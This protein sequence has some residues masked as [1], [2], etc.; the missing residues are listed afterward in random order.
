MPV[1]RNS[2]VHGGGFGLFA[3]R[4]FRKGEELDVFGGHLVSDTLATAVRDWGIGSHC[5]RSRSGL[6]LMCNPDPH[7]AAGRG[8]GTAQFANSVDAFEVVVH[9]QDLERLRALLPRVTVEPCEDGLFRVTEPARELYNAAIDR[10]PEVPRLVAARDVRVGEEL[11]TKYSSH[12]VPGDLERETSVACQTLRDLVYRG[13]RDQEEDRTI[14]LACIF[15]RLTTASGGVLVLTLSSGTAEAADRVVK[16]VKGSS[17]PKV[18]YC[19]TTLSGD[20]YVIEVGPEGAVVARKERGSPREEVTGIELEPYFGPQGRTFFRAEAMRYLE[21]YEDYVN[22]VVPNAVQHPSRWFAQLRSGRSLTGNSVLLDDEEALVVTD[23]RWDRS[24]LERLHVVCFFKKEGLYTIRDLRGAHVPLLESVMKR[25]LQA[26]SR[27]YRVAEEDLKLFF[28]Y[29]PRVYQLHLHL[30]HLDFVTRKSSVEKAHSVYSVIENL[31]LD[32][33]YY[34]KVRL[35]CKNTMPSE[36]LT[37]T[38][39]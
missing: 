27:R 38:F 14:R 13:V 39:H 21:P 19:A 4:D 25:A 32:P 16:A 6:V 33:D 15:L 3:D 17:R 29:R 37:R 22:V 2:L 36:H 23:S 5:I 10:S 30:I 8:Q 24:T 35:H 1:V 28:H 18:I 34:Q 26:V 31:K 9:G 7:D 11:F 12:S 20:E